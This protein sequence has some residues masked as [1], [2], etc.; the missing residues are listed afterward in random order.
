MTRTVLIVE[1]D[2]SLRRNVS[3][4]LVEDAY[5]VILA[6]TGGEALGRLR[7][8]VI[9]LILLDVGLPDCCGFSLFHEIRE[10]T[11]APV[12]F[13]TARTD[14]RD[15]IAGLE[16]GADD[17]V[18][19]PFA[20]RELQ[21]RIRNVLR[22]VYSPAIEIGEKHPEERAGSSEERSLIDLPPVS[23]SF[24]LQVDQE[25]Q[26]ITFYGTPLHTTRSEFILIAKLASKP[27]KIFSR[28]ELLDAINVDPNGPYDRSVDGHISK[29]RN[30]LKAV[31]A[32]HEPI[33]T[34]WALGYSLREEW[35]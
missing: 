18:N 22:R 13:M 32:E 21:V 23:S 9:D 35:S 11:K 31:N 17:Y 14:D 29:I 20:V 3:Y 33:V 16:Q 5:E 2:V 6:G 1:D 34:H 27:G 25:R 12:I 8:N 28:E 30:K 24:P 19:K 26:R 7:E 4:A 10:L 15:R